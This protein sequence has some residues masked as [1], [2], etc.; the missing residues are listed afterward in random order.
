M[1][2]SENMAAIRVPARRWARAYTRLPMRLVK[3][4]GGSSLT[5]AANRTVRSNLNSR[6]IR[7]SSSSAATPLAL[8]PA[9]GHP[10][11]ES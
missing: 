7:A 4:K 11:T 8:S 1:V 5:N 3:K 9:P 10:S 6:R 2:S